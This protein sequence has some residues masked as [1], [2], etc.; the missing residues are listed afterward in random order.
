MWHKGAQYLKKVGGII[1]IASII[2]WALG[3]F[4]RNINFSKDYDTIKEIEKN[5][6]R[7]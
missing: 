2:I 5:T 6:I 3:Y 1:L 7:K 4:P